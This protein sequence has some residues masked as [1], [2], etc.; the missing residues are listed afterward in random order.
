MKQKAKRFSALLTA[1]LLA[2]A[3]AGCGQQGSE[4]NVNTDSGTSVSD[5][6]EQNDSAAESESGN[7][8]SAEAPGESQN[9]ADSKADDKTGSKA[10]DDKTDSQAGSDES[11]KASDESTK[12][13]DSVS[14]GGNQT[15]SSTK[16]ANTESKAEASSKAESSQKA[17]S[18][19]ASGGSTGTSSEDESSEVKP[20]Y[21]IVLN[22]SSAKYSGEGISISGSK[23][24]ISKGGNFEITGTLDNGQIYIETDKKKVKLIL[25]NANITNKA[26]SAINCQAAKKVTIETLEGTVNNISD[27]G[28]HDADKGAIFSE[29]T[30]VLTGAGVLNING[31]YAHGV[32]S[33]DDIIVNGGTVNITSTKSGLH[34]NDGIE[35]NGGNLFCDGGTNGIKTDGYVTITGGSSVFLG[36]VREEKGAIYCDG[37][38][39]V[40][41]GSFWAIGNTCTMPDASATT[42]NVLALT[43]ANAQSANSIVNVMRG[44]STVFTMTSPRGYKYVLYSGPSLLSGAEYKVSYGGTVS[45]GTTLNYVTTGGSYSGGSDGGTIPSSET[46]EKIVTHTIP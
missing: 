46:T 39:T 27:G 41:G 30:V 35:I 19:A 28:T 4:G 25:N 5:P 1:L 16:P 8:E 3:L 18:S 37:P 6:A 42:A 40:T 26:G 24:T 17:E 23:I 32:Q 20:T 36:G 21:H 7:E 43:F 9:A 10:A 34:S 29:D 44:S 12:S 15:E 2:G 22:G 13:E 31:V 38:F 33:D 14:S 45:G 11:S